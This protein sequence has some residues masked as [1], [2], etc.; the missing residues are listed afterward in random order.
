MRV[1]SLYIVPLSPQAV[2]ILREVWPLIGHRKYAFPSVRSAT[3]PMSE[4]TVNAALRCLGYTT[5]EMTGYGFRHMAS[6]SL[7]EQGWKPDA[8]ERQLAYSDRD[9]VRAT[10]NYAE[11]LPERRKMMQAWADCHAPHV[12]VS[13]TCGAFHRDAPP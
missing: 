1:P 7:N 12:E 3:R 2:A 10:Y 5:E 13:V 8:I 4:N 9:E 11:Y 6:T